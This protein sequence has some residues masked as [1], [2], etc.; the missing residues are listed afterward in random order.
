MKISIYGV[1]GIFVIW[2][3]SQIY[4]AFIKKQDKTSQN[5]EKLLHAVNRIEERLKYTPTESEMLKM[6]DEKIGWY[7]E[8]TKE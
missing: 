1:G 2:A 4:A 3:S 6:I 5:V 8:R 7:H